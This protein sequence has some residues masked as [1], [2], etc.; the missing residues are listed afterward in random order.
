MIIVSDD[1]LATFALLRFGVVV[2]RFIPFDPDQPLLLPPDLREALPEGHEA[3]LLIDLVEQ[4]D[5]SGIYDE[6]PE[7]QWGGK[8]GF[9]P[10]VMVG[11]WLY[12][13]ARGIRSS[14]KVAEALV[15][16]IAFRVVANNQTPGHWALNRFRTRHREALGNLLAQTVTMALDMGLVKL[17]NVAIDG[18]KIKANASKHKAMSYGRMDAAEAKLKA[19]VDAYLEACDRQDEEDDAS[20]GPDDDGMSLPP[21]LRNRQARRNKIASAK[22]ELEQRA[23]DRRAAEQEKRAEVAG[24]EGRSYRARELVE[25]AIPK[26]SDQINFSDP[27]SRIMPSQGAFIQAYNAQASVDTESHFVLAAAVS[28]QV[29]D[30][31]HFISLSDETIA[32]TGRT[33]KRFS[34]DPGYYSDKNIL[35]AHELGVEALI[36]PDRI[37]GSE[38]R[39][40]QAPRGRIPKNLSQ[41]DRMRRKLATKEGKRYYL[42]R[43]ASVEPVFGNTKANRGLRQFLHRGLDKNHHLFRF[44]MAAHNALKILREVQ[45]ALKHVITDGRIRDQQR[46]QGTAPLLAA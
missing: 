36:P 13:Y 24:K 14:R 7:E 44:D 39:A 4:L 45:R 28:N 43:Q 41:Q 25:D 31:P 19:E 8:P 12:A 15:E 26:A 35:H 17:G 33:P 5:L 9:D 23:R 10:R 32:N 11:V 30:A 21:E 42:Q 29:A 16:N 1:V 34:A 22:R 18:S 27:E 2:K 40:Q 37:R 38:W 46:N 20:F 6:L 3:L